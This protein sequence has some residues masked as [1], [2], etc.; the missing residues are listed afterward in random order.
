LWGKRPV[1]LVGGLKNHKMGRKYVIV[2]TPPLV[3]KEIFER[4]KSATNPA[5]EKNGGGGTKNSRKKKAKK[6][7][8]GVN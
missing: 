1:I 3:I 6:Q 5:E 7:T 8:R 2:G 4:K